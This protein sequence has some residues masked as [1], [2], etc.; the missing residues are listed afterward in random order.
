MCFI[1][2]RIKMKLIEPTMEYEKELQAF[3]QDFLQYEGSMEGS[4]S[5]KRYDNIRDWIEQLEQLKY[6]E[7]TPSH[8]VPQTQYIYVREEDKKVIGV[9]QIRHF[10]NDSLRKF[11]GHIGYSVCPSERR[12]GYATQMLKEALPICKFLGIDDV[13]I[14]CSDNNVGSRK[15]IQNN[16][17]VFETTVLEPERNISFERYWIHL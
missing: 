17:G 2:D 14:M 10:L 5:L 6:I 15:V 1:C 9:I 3:R 12:K 4:G 16:G 11:G 7:T 13:L 8:L